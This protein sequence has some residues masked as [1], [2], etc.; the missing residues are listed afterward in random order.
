MLTLDLTVT[1]NVYFNTLFRRHYCSLT[2]HDDISLLQSSRLKLKNK[3]EIWK[4]F[5]SLF[6]LSS[7]ILLLP[8]TDKGDANELIGV[9]KK[10]NEVRYA[11]LKYPQLMKTKNQP[12]SSGSP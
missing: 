5:M 1:E 9:E 6:F 2:A 4:V 3:V 8:S 12:K 7:V 10:T 11:K